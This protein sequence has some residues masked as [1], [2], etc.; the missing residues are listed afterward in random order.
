MAPPCLRNR[1]GKY[2]SSSASRDSVLPI[3]NADASAAESAPPLRPS[4][5][6]D[7]QEQKPPKP[8]AG[9]LSRWWS[10]LRPRSA[11]PDVRSAGIH[12]P[13]QET[14]RQYSPTPRHAHAHEGP[15]ETAQ[16]KETSPATTAQAQ[17]LPLPAS[18]EGTIGVVDDRSSAATPLDQQRLSVVGSERDRSPG[19]HKCPPELASEKKSPLHMGT[20]GPDVEEVP[21][22]PVRPERHLGRT[23]MNGLKIT[24]NVMKEAS[25][26][27]PP[28]QSVAGGLLAIV[29]VVEQVSTNEADIRTVEAYV[30]QLNNM[31]SPT[32]LPPMAQWPSEFKKRLDDFVKELKKIEQDMQCLASETRAGRVVNARERAGKVSEHV[33]S[34]GRV[35]QTFIVS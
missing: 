6:S 29:D 8:Q 17:D 26:A 1:W 14:E 33:Q 11:P 9:I 12:T 34:L 32:S 25:A 15:Q 28:L 16:Q 5:H 18:T 20:L 30:V 19:T 31:V 35:V 10:T 22:Q 27:F 4:L 2:R 21:R 23:L 3:P 13:L 7:R 24:L